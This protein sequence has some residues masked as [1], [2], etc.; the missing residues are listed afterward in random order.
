M[1]NHMIIAVYK[2]NEGKEA[3]LLEIVRKHLPALREFGLVTDRDGYVAQSQDGS[4][5]EI[6]EWA[7]PDASEKAHKHPGV[8]ALWDAMG[9][10]ASFPT[11]K[12]LPEATTPFPSFT[13]IQPD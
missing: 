8:M 1:S 4:I 9:A 3:E 12:E 5:V 13:T 6:F 2:P 7:G 11:L 10:V